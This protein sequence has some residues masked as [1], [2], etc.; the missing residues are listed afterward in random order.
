[1]VRRVYINAV[2]IRSG[3]GLI[4]LKDLLFKVAQ[5]TEFYLFIDASLRKSITKKNHIEYVE[6]SYKQ[7]VYI[8]LKLKKIMSANDILICLNNIPPIVRP[9]GKVIVFLQNCHILFPFKKKSISIKE[10][11]RL[12]ILNR[13]LAYG[14]KNSDEFLIQTPKMQ[15]DLISSFPK[16]KKVTLLPWVPYSNTIAHSTVEKDN[17]TS[18]IYPASSHIHKNHTRV[19]QAWQLLKLKS[20]FPELLLTIN[21]SEL[22]QKAQEIINENQDLNIKFLSNL[23]YNKIQHYYSTCHALIFPSLEESF[24]LPLWEAENYKLP[25]LASNLPFVTEVMDQV[26]LFDPNQPRSIAESV[27]HFIKTKKRKVPRR[28][29]QTLSLYEYLSK[30]KLTP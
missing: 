6:N 17:V 15:R 4:L 8:D 30:M 7:R 3:G 19:I 16:V 9:K 21:K 29:I 18:L 27:E 2:G 24:G 5:K 26:Y 22:P 1:M 28:K 20:L 12:F 13:L 25:T 14:V 23:P 11:L 10:R